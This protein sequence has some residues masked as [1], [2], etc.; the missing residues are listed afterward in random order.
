MTRPRFLVLLI[1]GLVLIGLGVW[2]A[3]AASGPG[4]IGKPIGIFLLVIP[5]ALLVVRAF[6]GWFATPGNLRAKV[7]VLVGLGSVLGLIFLSERHQAF[8]LEEKKHMIKATHAHVRIVSAAAI[9]K[10][11]DLVPGKEPGELEF[12]VV[13]IVNQPIDVGY[14]K[15]YGA[16][17]QIVSDDGPP[18]DTALWI[19]FVTSERVEES[20]NTYVSTRRSFFFLPPNSVEIIKYP[21]GTLIKFLVQP[22]AGETGDI[23]WVHFKN[24]DLVTWQNSELDPYY[25]IDPA[26]KMREVLWYRTKTLEWKKFDPEW[27]DDLRDDWVSKIETDE[28]PSGNPLS[29]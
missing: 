25:D 18:R 6:L 2:L 4:W 22:N 26:P 19:S 1:S 5:G 11:G 29:L 3:T 7:I 23:D 27:G 12:E 20:G 10:I 28:V 14:S 8:L 16:P 24:G 9:E 17:G 13:G 15:A 21:P